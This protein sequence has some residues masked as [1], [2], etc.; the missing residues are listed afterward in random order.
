M[1]TS[2]MIP[3]ALATL[4]LAMLVDSVA[5]AQII[6]TRGLDFDQFVAELWTDAQNRGI[7][8]GIFN[9]VLSGVTPD[10]RVIA[11]TKKQ[12]EYNKP[13]GAYV[14]GVAT[15]SNAAE[16]RRKETQ[17]RQT[18][19]TV[20]RRYQV[21]RWIILATWGMETS[22][23][24][25]KDK[26]DGVRSLSTLAFAK[27]RDRYF[28]DELLVALKLI[29]DGQIGREKFATSWAGA[30]GQPQFMPTTF[31]DYAVDFDGDGKPDIWTS[32][33]DVLGSIA[34]YLKRSG[35]TDGMPWGFEV[36]VPPGFDMMKSHGSFAEWTKLELARADGRPFPTNGDGILFFPAGLPGPAFIVTSN[37]D[38]IKTYNDSDVYALAVGHLSD[39]MQGGV[40]FKSS[41][42]QQATQ[43]PREDRIALQ[44]KLAALGYHQ[45]RFTAHIDFKMRDFVRTEQKKY[46][47]LTDGHPTPT[48]LDKMGVKRAR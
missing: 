46:G 42:P 3:R 14:A 44:Q 18:L 31:R 8:R 40:P 16:G 38:V 39:L 19:D 36:N 32:V 7:S 33:P 41:W 4:A 24:A 17:W 26:W 22:Y 29:Q 10:P 35:W 20:E 15:A 37:F 11:T 30:M 48:L 25:L 34:N 9:K 28:R 12:P 6:H 45:T 47:L 5:E 27:F 13:V 2:R 23:G 1:K 21:E 43:L